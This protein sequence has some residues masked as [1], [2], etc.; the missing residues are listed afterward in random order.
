L[1]LK[2]YSAMRIFL[3]HLVIV[4]LVTA[5][6]PKTDPAQL[7]SFHAVKDSFWEV[8]P[9]STVAHRIGIDF[10]FTEGPA[11]LDDGSL[12]FSDIPANTIY[13]WT[14]K[15]YETFRQPSGNS[16][17]L[18]VEPDGS[19]L[20]C[21]HDSRSVTRISESGRIDTIAR[22]YRGL[23]FNSPNDLCMTS[24][25]IIF[26]TDPPWGL[27][28]LNK[29]PSKEIPFNGV[30]RVSGSRID[31][32]DSTLSWPNGIALSPDERSLYVANFEEAQ[33][34][35]GKEMEVFWVRYSL[36]SNGDI[37][38]REIFYRAEDLDKPGGPD[39]M[40]TDRA[41]NLFLTG[42]GGILVVSPGGELLGTIALPKV[43]ANLTFGPGEQDLY[44]TA[45]SMVIQIHLHD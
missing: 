38:G 8:V 6:N 20:A 4:I 40:K 36:D 2:I 32:V 44:V 28:G 35:E 18:L 31:L 25:G 29:D 19:I 10:Q 30:Y 7:G 21:E 14:G 41:G 22:S 33:P 34:G 42:P 26:F 13:R 43:P 15:Q 27:N 37:I 1:H 45:E 24:A 9:R 5:C 3:F 23:R 16:N 11:V 12:I 17:G 39:G